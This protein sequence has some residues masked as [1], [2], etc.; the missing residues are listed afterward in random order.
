METIGKGVVIQVTGELSNAGQP[1]RKFLQ[2]FVLAPQ[3]ST[4]YYAKNDIFRYQDEI[5]LDD[6][7]YSEV[8]KNIDVGSEKTEVPSL[9]SVEREENELREDSNA[10]VGTEYYENT[11][12]S[13]HEIIGSNVEKLSINNDPT[14]DKTSDLN[15]TDNFEDETY[16]KSEEFIDRNSTS[17][18]P[19]TNE[20]K[21]YANM[22]SKNPN[23]NFPPFSGISTFTTSAKSE[24]NSV[25]APF[26][27]PIESSPI[28][29]IANTNN[30]VSGS[31]LSGKPPT[32]NRDGP[33]KENRAIRR[34]R[35]QFN[36]RN[37]SREMTP[38]R[39]APN[40][41]DDDFRDKK[42][43]PDENQVFV[44]N[45]PQHIVEENLMTLFTKFGKILDVRIN[46]Q[47]QKMASNAKTPNYGF[48]TFENQDIVQL[49]LKQKVF[50]SNLVF[51]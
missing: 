1:M 22:V 29:S 39:V 31:S 50:I 32:N 12:G 21:T 44:G 46:R 6:D 26:T 43:Y 38:G 33:P 13:V 9:K 51:I 19:R 10:T 3:S 4:K 47:N 35:Q 37:E 30:S 17:P 5:F 14:D 48:V 28:P 24:T 27:R 8:E 2:T 41:S 42:Q 23:S 45:L 36:R 16:L 34:D 25:S 49:I 20:L 40:D 11:N 15:S 7:E 18:Q